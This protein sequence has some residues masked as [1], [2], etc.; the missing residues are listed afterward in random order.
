MQNVKNVLGQ[1][2]KQTKKQIERA[3]IARCDTWHLAIKQFWNILLTE[4]QLCVT[5]IAR[6]DTPLCFHQIKKN[7]KIK[8]DATSV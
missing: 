6:Q 2:K 7:K 3:C 1:K 8:K 4:N 5:R